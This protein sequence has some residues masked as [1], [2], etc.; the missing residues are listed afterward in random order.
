MVLYKHR[1]V[2]NP[3]ICRSINT[4]GAQI[5]TAMDLHAHR[6]SQILIAVVLYMH[7]KGVANPNSCT[8]FYPLD[9]T[10]GR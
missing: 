9:G 4:S 3:N 10:E 6:G 7:I 5:L 2:A 1:G 8:G